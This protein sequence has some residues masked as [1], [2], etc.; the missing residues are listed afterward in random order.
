MRKPKV[1]QA[2]KSHGEALKPCEN[3]AKP[4]WLPE[5][6]LHTAPAS[7]SISLLPYERPRARTAQLSSP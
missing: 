1:A 4:N 6:A 7:A 2:E 5:L 3:K